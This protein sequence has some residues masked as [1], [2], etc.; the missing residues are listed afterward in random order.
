MDGICERED[1]SYIK[2]EV[3]LDSGACVPERPVSSMVEES[4]VREEW[5]SFIAERDDLFTPHPDEA[6]AKRK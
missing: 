6:L 5:T 1:Q 2:P 3:C 4:A